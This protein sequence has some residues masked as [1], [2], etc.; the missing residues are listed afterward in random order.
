MSK[1]EADLIKEENERLTRERD[2]FA[3]RPAP[4]KQQVNKRREVR[5]NETIKG[6]RGSF[7]DLG[8]DKD[9]LDTRFDELKLKKRRLSADIEAPVVAQ[10]THI[11]VLF[12]SFSHWLRK[13]KRL[14]ILH[15]VICPSC[16]LNMITFCTL[17]LLL[18]FALSI[19]QEESSA[20]SRSIRWYMVRCIYLLSVIIISHLFQHNFVLLLSRKNSSHFLT[21]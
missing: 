1:Y 11:H 8:K 16:T 13:T 6:L 12:V 2:E 17:L 15:K 3:Q 9:K 14:L 20:S 21:G 4:H 18:V 19:F 7:K 5:H 10:L